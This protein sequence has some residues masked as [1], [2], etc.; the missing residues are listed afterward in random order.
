LIRGESRLEQR[1]D[2]LL[3]RPGT[4][5][6]PRTWLSIWGVL[7]LLG[8]RYRLAFATRVLLAAAATLAFWRGQAIGGGIVL[9][10]FLTYFLQIPL[11]IG[12]VLAERDRRRTGG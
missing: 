4:Q 12:I 2:A 11:I 9:A 5:R 1:L 7:I 10:L 8:F 3:S 6:S